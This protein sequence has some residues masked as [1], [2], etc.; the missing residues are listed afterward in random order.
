ITPNRADLLSYRGIAREVA[1]LTRKQA[2]PA[3]SSAVKEVVTS[4]IQI[5]ATEKCPFYTARK[6]SGVKVGPSPDW[7]RNKLEASGIRSINNIVDI[8]NFV[9]LEIGQPLHAFDA[10]KLRG[11]IRVRVANDGEEFLA[12][13]GRTYK[14]GTDD[15]LIADEQRAIAIAGVMGGEE[16]GVT[17]TTTNILLESAYFQPAS[18]RRTARKLG[19][20]SDSS[21]RF[22]RG[23]DPAGVLAASQR[24]TGL[25]SELASGEAAPQIESAGAAPDFTRAVTLRKGR[26]SQVLG[27]DVPGEFIRETLTRFGLTTSGDHVWRVPSFRQ[28]L[29]REI[30]LIEEVTRVFG[31][32][33]IPAREMSRY[34]AES[35]T[36]R[37]HDRRMQIR[38]TL[39]AQ[40]FYEARTL[41]LIEDTPDYALPASIRVRNPLTS[42]QVMLRPT[43]V[44]GVLDVLAHNA[45][46]GAKSQRIFEIGRCFLAGEYEETSKLA[47]VMTGTLTEKSWRSGD[48]RNADLFDMKG[49]LGSLGLGEL[50]YEPMENPRVA[51]MASVSLNGRRIGAIGV[52]LPARAR[53]LDVTTPV[54]IAE[55]ELPAVKATAKKFAGIS[56]F[57]AVTRDIAMLA[58]KEVRHAQVIETLQSVNEPLLASAELF[59]IFADETGEKVPRGQKSLAYSLT[60]RSR[61]RTLTADEVNAA[62]ARLKERLKAV[63]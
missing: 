2:A 9:M 52:L 50:V 47:L 49:V 8:T 27:T 12:L 21:Y 16:T 46:A 33:N 41:S 25:I 28:D 43:L 30:D 10:D 24:A 35:Q 40:G 55:I 53:E 31:I 20:I 23:V 58:P 60:Y 36:D 61:E 29:T 51:V 14:L 22:E 62:H 44:R 57:P 3:Q 34:F 56:K 26:C 19:L 4:N 39:I 37:E 6:I 59:D 63:L 38:R 32:E 11:G 48:E 1:A 15:L 45:R 42:D 5:A 18:I 54:I 17:E 13:D 7:L